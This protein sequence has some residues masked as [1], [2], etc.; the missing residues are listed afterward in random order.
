MGKRRRK[1]RSPWLLGILPSRRVA[2]VWPVFFC[3][4]MAGLLLGHH[5]WSSSR[6]A[7]FPLS[8][9][10]FSRLS[11]SFLSLFLFFFFFLLSA[12]INFFQ[13]AYQVWF[14]ERTELFQKI[15]P[16]RNKLPNTTINTHT[17][18][19]RNLTHFFLT[20]K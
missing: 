2:M 8:L 19:E 4:G 18:E 14:C 6:Y 12:V 15:C 5:G 3:V 10:L 1:K 17:G 7:R 11:S 20:S 16:K 9:F 13:G